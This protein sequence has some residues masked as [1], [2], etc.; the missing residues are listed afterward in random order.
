MVFDFN[1]RLLKVKQETHDVKTFRF[2]IP[3]EFTFLPGQ[4]VMVEIGIDGNSDVRPFSISSSPTR[5]GFIEVTKKIGGSDFSKRLNK[6]DDS[7][8]ARVKGPYGMFVLDESHDAILLAGGIGV[9]PFRC[10]MEYATDKDLDN[11]ITL[12]YSNKTPEDV[13][14]AAEFEELKRKNK[15]IKIISTIT[16]R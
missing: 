13:A 15:N 1:A 16:R 5:K 10:F 12:F 8:S 9:T 14:F 2:E 3:K 11:K 4:F 7:Y 6:M